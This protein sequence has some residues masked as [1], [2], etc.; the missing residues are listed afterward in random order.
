MKINAIV[1]GLFLISILVL[2]GCAQQQIRTET[3]PAKVDLCNE[4]SNPSASVNCE[5][6]K[7]DGTS[8]SIDCYITVSGDSR[9]SY[10]FS[11]Y[12]A[13]GVLGGQTQ[14]G[15]R[16]KLNSNNQDRVE[17]TP[18][19]TSNYKECENR[20]IIVYRNQFTGEVIDNSDVHDLYNR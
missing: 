11:E 8:Y 19:D 20:K 6:N 10:R 2:S 13:W 16:T 5:K 1:I 7:I 4:I 9:V 15:Q 17:V 12:G 18:Y 3:Q 14:A